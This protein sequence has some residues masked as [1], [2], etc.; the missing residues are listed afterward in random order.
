MNMR[1]RSAL[2][3]VNGFLFVA[4]VALVLSN[5]LILRQTQKISAATFLGPEVKLNQR[6]QRRQSSLEGTWITNSQDVLDSARRRPEYIY[7][8]FL[9]RLPSDKQPALN[10]LLVARFLGKID[11]SSILSYSSSRKDIEEFEEKFDAMLHGVLTSDEEYRAFI[12]FEKTVPTLNFFYHLQ[13]LLSAQGIALT[14]E[15]KRQMTQTYLSNNVE[16]EHNSLF[17]AVGLSEQIPSEH[18]LESWNLTPRQEEELHLLIEQLR[19]EN[20]VYDSL[21]S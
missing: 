5:L 17:A 6:V 19:C 8:D 12:A 15:Q 7:N 20:D 11:G 18:V 21:H 13:N 1:S 2:R 4:L 3:Y 9:S 10:K 16:V 14:A